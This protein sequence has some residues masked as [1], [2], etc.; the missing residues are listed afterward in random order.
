ML[1]QF[2][3]IA[4]LLFISTLTATAQDFRTPRPSPDA[5]VSQYVGITKITIDY[6]SPGVKGRK[7]WGELVPY[8]EIW[9]TGANEVTSITFGDPVKINGNELPAGTFGIH[10]IP[11]ENEWEI[12][13]SK[14]TEIDGSSNYD[15]SKDA[16]RIKVKPEEHHFMERMTFLF[17]DVTENSVN[18]NLVWENLMVSFKLEV[19]TEELTLDKARKT[20]SWAP[21]FQAAQYFLQKDTNL[22]EAMK[23]I[24]ASTLLSE[25]YWNTRVKAQI[26]YKL[27]MKSEAIATME[28]AIELGSKMDSAP[29]DYDNMKKMLEEWKK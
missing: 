29:F 9:R 7:I 2:K 20:L 19:N 6:S 5:T 12:I 11:G 4:L 25:V 1:K 27:G 18:V 24:E 23:W 28:K 16:L 14:D 10:T 17:A 21:S 22:D 15:P 8:G 3:Y 13:F 26:Q